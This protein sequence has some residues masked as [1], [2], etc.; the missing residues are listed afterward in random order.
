[1]KINNLSSLIYLKFILLSLS[2]NKHLAKKTLKYSIKKITAK[3]TFAVRHPVLRQGKPIES[4]MFDGDN[5][6]TTF[7]LGIFHKDKLVGISSFLMS[8]HPLLSQEF[9]YQLR[10]MAVLNAYQNLGL[11]KLILN[12]GENLL[13]KQNIQI[14]WCNAREKAVN[15]YK[16]NDYK[17]IGLPFDIKD[18]GKH[19]VMYKTL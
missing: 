11:G 3:E 19:F 6:E 17:I 5:L 16:K 1:M 8:K 2:I 13:K 14:V 9:Q 7:H 10:G 12:H 15:F 18:I 4:C